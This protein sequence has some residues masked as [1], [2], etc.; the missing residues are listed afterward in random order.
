MNLSFLDF[1]PDT[2]AVLVISLE[3]IDDP[4]GFVLNDWTPSFFQYGYIPVLSQPD[5]DVVFSGIQPEGVKLQIT[6][7]SKEVQNRVFVDNVFTSLLP[8]ESNSLLL[9]FYQYQIIELLLGQVFEAEQKSLVE[10]L[11]SY[12]SDSVKTKEVL[13][14]INK[15][16]S[17]KKRLSL[18]FEN[19]MND[20]FEKS[21][22]VAACNSFLN[23]HNRETSTNLHES[24]YK[25]R[26]VL[27]HQYRDVISASGDQLKNICQEFSYLLV[28]LVSNYRAPVSS[29]PE[30]IPLET[31]PASS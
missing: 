28:Q 19:Y 3:K 27:F 26:N 24:L 17:E 18:L 5:R 14:E 23:S 7:V 30:T 15:I 29:H 25:V 8:Y 20:T 22:L 12:A 11:I 31:E 13:D 4:N 16:S 10:K 2:T 6:P 1:F 9:F 21:Q